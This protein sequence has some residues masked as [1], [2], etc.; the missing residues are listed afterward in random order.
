MSKYNIIGDIHGRTSWKELVQDDCTN[1][2][3]GDYFDPYESTTF[4]DCMSNMN[5][6]ISYKEEHPN[7]ILLI[8]NHDM[9][10][11]IN[12][13][14][15]RKMIEHIDDIKQFF[16]ENKDKF[17]IAYNIDDVIVSHAGIS[18]I[19]YLYRIYNINVCRI[20]KSN[21]N[22]TDFDKE[23]EDYYSNGIYQW[24]EKDNLKETYINNTKEMSVF[25][26][27]NVDYFRMDNEWIEFTDNT[28]TIVRNINSLWEEQNLYKPF[29]FNCNASSFDCFGDSE[30]HSPIW[31]RP[32]S[33]D[34]C[35]LCNIKQVIGHTQ[36]KNI[37]SPNKDDNSQIYMV[38][39]LGFSTESLIY[40]SDTKTFMI[41][42]I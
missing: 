9:Q 42:K 27:C 8:G 25:R 5:D 13:N 29:S 1:I 32:Y 15:S 10:Y 4:E 6:I 24:N 41:N 22:V 19:W 21:G 20:W 33:L 23:I 11:L 39:C 37:I 17:Q 7:T 12:E 31:I 18:I 30:T 3:V 40:D 36:N 2:F 28:D 26:N 14:Y 35:G 16:E 34:E 38:D